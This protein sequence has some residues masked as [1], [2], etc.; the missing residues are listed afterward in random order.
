MHFNVNGIW[1]TTPTTNLRYGWNHYVLVYD[2]VNNL[3]RVYLNNILS[4]SH[5]TNGNMV[6]GDF[7]IGVATNLN[8][9]YRGNISNFKVY[10]KALTAQEIQQNFNATRSRYSI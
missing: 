9:Y 2:T 4:S 5:A 1:Q 8:A 6:L 7:R 10:N 3:K